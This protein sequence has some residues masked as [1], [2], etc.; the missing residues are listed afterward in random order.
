MKKLFEQVNSNK[1][2]QNL[3]TRWTGAPKEG[4][5]AATTLAAAGMALS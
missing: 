2:F 3:Q 4:N 5:N 1:A